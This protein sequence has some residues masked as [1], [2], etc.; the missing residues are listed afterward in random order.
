[1]F[2]S[3][4]YCTF[5]FCYFLSLIS[6]LCKCYFSL[7]YRT[8]DAGC[9]PA[10]DVYNIG[11]NPQYRLEIKSQGSA[12]VWCL[13]TRHITDIEDFKDNKEYISLLVYDTDG[14]RVYYPCKY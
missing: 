5:K 12:A 6:S 7:F 8:W 11:E 13:L 9:G 14:K 4:K 10:K 2:T 1:M 3:N